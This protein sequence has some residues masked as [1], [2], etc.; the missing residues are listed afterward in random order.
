LSAVILAS[1]VPYVGVTLASI[2]RGSALTPLPV[3]YTL[4][5]CG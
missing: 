1:F 3:T 2:R 5:Y 4:A